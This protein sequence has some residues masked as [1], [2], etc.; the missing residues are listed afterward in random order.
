MNL[1]VES[2]VRLPNVSAS[3]RMTGACEQAP[4]QATESS[5]KLMSGVVP[6]SG[7]PS[8]C[9]RA[10][11]MRGAP[12]TWQAVPWQ[13]KTLCRPLGSVENWA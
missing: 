4:M 7:T 9:S 11:V 5:V 10:S 2:G 12:A 13:T 8:S 6:P 1:R 3:M